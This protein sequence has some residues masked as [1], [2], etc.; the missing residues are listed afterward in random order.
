VAD[1]ILLVEDEVLIRVAICHHLEDSGYNVLQA[2]DA[3]EAL[4]LLIR[5]PELDV[6]FTDVRMP[7]S[8]DGLG[9]AKWVIEHRPHIA[10][11]VASG[12]AAK[13]TIVKELCGAMAFPKPYNFEN[14][15]QH[16]QEAIRNRRHN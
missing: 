14:V 16:I 12:G 7:G 11:M 10:V 13:D 15:T 8:I 1:T 6:V 9:L 3:D 4:S 2:T 5:H